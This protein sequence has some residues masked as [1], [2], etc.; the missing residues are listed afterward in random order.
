MV[1]LP[2]SS[3][4]RAA[5]QAPATMRSLGAATR[6]PSRIAQ[7]CGARGSGMLIGQPHRFCTP[8][9]GQRAASRLAD[10]A[11]HAAPAGSAAVADAQ[12]PAQAA[13]EPR[14]EARQ[15]REFS[16]NLGIRE[17]LVGAS[18]WGDARKGVGEARGHKRASLQAASQCMRPAGRPASMAVFFV[19]RQPMTVHILC[20]HVRLTHWSC[21]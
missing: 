18:T 6:L 7:Q 16:P 21:Q 13:G 20:W 3:I 12:Q 10:A 5:L 15:R 1:N 2:W 17:L 8:A 9:A 11:P 4:L 14:C 19:P